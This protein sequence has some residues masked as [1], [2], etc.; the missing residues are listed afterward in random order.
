MRPNPFL[1]PVLRFTQ[2]RRDSR[3]PFAF[4]PRMSPRLARLPRIYRTYHQT[5]QAPKKNDRL[6]RKRNKLLA[7]AADGKS[8]AILAVYAPLSTEKTGPCDIRATPAARRVQPKLRHGRAGPA[9]RAGLRGKNPEQ[10]GLAV[11]GRCAGFKR[12]APSRAPSDHHRHRRSD[13]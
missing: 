10:T 2:S 8:G 13:A 12:P 5:C 9:R 1:H 4:L 11:R 6:S 3:P 7:R